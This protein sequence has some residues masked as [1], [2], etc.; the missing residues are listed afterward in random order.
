MFC[1]NAFRQAVAEESTGEH[2]KPHRFN[3]DQ[4]AWSR[5]SNRRRQS[6]CHFCRNAKCHISSTHALKLLVSSSELTTGSD[7]I[8]RGDN[9]AWRENSVSSGDLPGSTSRRI[10]HVPG[11]DLLHFHPFL[12]D[13]YALPLEPCGYSSM[14]HVSWAPKTSVRV[15]LVVCL[16]RSN[17]VVVSMM[18]RYSCSGL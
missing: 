1:W 6:D 9:L 15:F 12:A 17:G 7:L 18:L 3:K 11:V 14:C 5:I 10:L 4:P 16:L 13:A 2:R 8:F